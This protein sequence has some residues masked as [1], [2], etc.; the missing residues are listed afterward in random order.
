M[1]L[2]FG[3]ALALLLAAMARVSVV[4]LR[5]DRSEAEAR[6]QAALEE[7]VRLALWRI[8]SALAPLIA[9]EN[10]RPYFAYSSFYP[11]ERAYTRML[12]R[13]EPGEVL[14]P[15]PLLSQEPPH[16]LVH[17]HLKP[18]GVLT[19]P[20]APTGDMQALAEGG[21]T[22]RERVQTYARRLQELTQL[23]DRDTVLA[24]LPRE[25]VR[26]AV[27]VRMPVVADARRQPGGQSS[28]NVAEWRVRAQQHEQTVAQNTSLV[29]PAALSG[30]VKEGGLLPLWMGQALVLARRVV[31]D[32]EVYI[33]GCWLDWT[34]LQEDLTRAVQDL[35]PAAR[36][37][38]VRL[39][40][41]SGPLPRA[42]GDA[43]DAI[44]EDGHM[45]AALPVRLVPGS[46]PFEGREGLSP[47]RLSLLMAWTCIMAVAVAVAVLLRG[48][49]SLSE[50]RGAFVSAVTHEL[51]T[52]LTT[53]R[54]YTEM[55]AEDMVPD[56]QKR[57]S[58]LDT[59]RAEADRLRHLVENV[60]AYARLEKAGKV[61]RFEAVGVGEL[62]DR[63]KDR[64]ADRAREAGMQ[65]GAEAGAEA[66]SLM[67]RA[68]AAA[69]EQILFNLVDNA[70]KYAANADD[71]FIRLE[72]RRKDGF[73]AVAVR[74]H[75]PGISAT[76]ARTV[77]LPFRKSA[78]DAAN[79]ASGVGLGLAL[80][81]R[82]AREMGGD[83][84]ID[85]NVTD[86]ACF[87]LTL[88]LS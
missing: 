58:Y 10:A 54:M 82:L 3:V 6:H 72:V 79:S 43:A 12:A 11:A 56:E 2:A 40:A 84:R 25:E 80:S 74:D 32:R 24:A 41:G 21:Y 31:V 66:L 27:P 28:R 50:R 60:L 17:F 47:I 18:D 15:S 37:E 45:L 13:I 68:D 64:L 75:G 49:V 22:T 33:Q 63:M 16:V 83:L 4:A 55:L 48:L 30:D 9:V 8:D 7:N 19:S 42:H 38:P 71:P 26:T 39:P 23:L 65:R 67:V 73:A 69:V 59:L 46:L 76:D 87:V 85:G 1:W 61:G 34:G 53:F 78:R 5:V 14:V 29:N 86:G 77:F 62:L 81:R 51:R 88:P 20:Q 35:L 57:R 44:G 36:L 52:P 70:C